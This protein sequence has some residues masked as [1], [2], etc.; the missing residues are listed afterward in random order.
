MWWI[1]RRPAL[2]RGMRCFLDRAP[3]SQASTA[4][5]RT[6]KSVSITF[7]V[8]GST[9][10]ICLPFTPSVRPTARGRTIPSRLRPR[11]RAV[12]GP[13]VESKGDTRTSIPT[14]E[15]WVTSRNSLRRPMIAASRSP[16]TSPFNV[17]PIILT[18]KSTR[19]GFISVPTGLFNTPRTRRK[20]TRTFTPW[21]FQVNN[22]AKSGMSR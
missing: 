3:L 5:L 22:G 6:A 2:A 14:W 21:N 9:C 20:S 11:I 19:T 1:E 8:W 4:P 10:S 16:W 18:S 13:L 12:R 17:H 15:L 7:Q